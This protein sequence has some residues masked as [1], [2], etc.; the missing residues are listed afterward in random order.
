MIIHVT[1]PAAETITLHVMPGDT[2]QSVKINIK[3]R[4]E[5]PPD[6]QQLFLKGMELKNDRTLSDYNIASDC[7]LFVSL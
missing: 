2:V 6:L 5:I 3:D 1:T 4:L 7:T